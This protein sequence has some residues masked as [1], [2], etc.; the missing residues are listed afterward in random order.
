MQAHWAEAVVTLPGLRSPAPRPAH[1]RVAIASPVHLVREGLAANLRHRQGVV[2]V[3]TVD[4]EP[5][6]MARIADAKPDIVLVDFGQTAPAAAARLIKAASPGCKLVAFAVDE[7]GDQIFA[8]AAAG[9]CGYVPRQSSAEEL[10]GALVDAMAGRMQCAPHIAAAMFSRLAGLLREPEPPA[11]LPSLS[12]RESEILALVAEGRSNKEIAR[13]LEISAATVKNHM[14]NILQ[15]L[16][17][18]R[19]GEAAARLRMS[20]AS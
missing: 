5:H 16:Q 12:A 10:Y 2:L 20:H 7:T 3:D 11:S 13:R 14:H 9:F 19:R 4:L 1:I 17:V 18:G 15:K 8:C 6:G